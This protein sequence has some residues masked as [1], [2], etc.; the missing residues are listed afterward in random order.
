MQHSV[1]FSRSFNYLSVRRWLGALATVLAVGTLTGPA[2]GTPPPGGIAPTSF[3][4]FCRLYHDPHNAFTRVVAPHAGRSASRANA[5]NATL[6]SIQ[7]NYSNFT[8]EA[9][10]AFQAAVDIWETQLNSPV[11][12][13]VDAQFLD[14]GN[15]Q[16]LGFGAFS[17]LSFDF[18]GAPVNGVLFPDPIASRLS[19]V[20][21]NGAA[22]EIGV[23]LNT[24]PNWNYATD[25]VP[26]AGK[27]DFMSAVLH[28]LGHGFGLAGSGTVS[29]RGAL[30]FWGISGRPY[31]YDLFVAD[32]AN[33]SILDVT[34]YPNFS[35]ELGTLLRGS[36][37]SGP[38]LFWNGAQGVAANGGV[39]PRL[40]APVPF[41]PGY[42]YSHLDS[43]MFPPGDMNSLM[44]PSLASAE[45]IH[46]PGAIA[47]AMLADMGWGSQCSFGLSRRL[48]TVGAAGG[49][50]TATLSTSAGCNW[51]A[52]TTSPFATITAGGSGSASAVVAVSIAANGGGAPRLA[53]VQIADQTLTIAQAGASPCAY[54]LTPTS[55]SIGGAGGTGTLAL[56]TI[57]ACPWT[58]TANPAEALITSATSGV[59]PATVTYSIVPNPTCAARQVTL[60]IAGQPFVITQAPAP[61][62]MA[63]D[64]TSMR[65]GAVV[66]GAAFAAHTSGQIARLAQ[67]GPGA[68]TWTAVSSAPWLVVTPASGSGPAT[69][70][71]STQYVGSLAASQTGTVTLTY[72]GASNAS[73]T[74]S[75]A[76]AVVSN[77]SVAPF[78]S[79]D[80]PGD[81]ESGI[82]G[83]LPVTGWALDDVEVTRVRIL[84]DPV[85]GEP[86][87]TLVYIGDADLVNGA[88]PDLQALHPAL[89]RNSRAGW[90]YLMLTNFL[91]SLGNGVFRLTAI[92]DDAQGHSTVLGSKTITV[93][94]A[95]STAPF[96]AI[97]TPTQG[98]TVSGTLTN[99]GWVLSPAPRRA[100]P[101]AGGTVQ[102]VVDGAFVSASPGGWTS[103]PDLTALFPVAQY[104]GIATALAVAVLDTTVLSN[105]VHTIA[106][107][108]TD[109]Q[110]T[111]SGVGS[112]YFTVA[113]DV[114][115]TSG[116]CTALSV[117]GTARAAARRQVSTQ[118]AG[119]AALVWRRG[120]DRHAPY[121]T[122]Q[123]AADGRFTIESEEID[124]LE[125]QV[126][127]GA[128]GHLRVAGELA[129]LPSGS[130]LDAPTGTFT[131]QP[132]VGFVG[133]YD[134]LFGGREVR[135]VLRP[136]G[137][138]RVGPQIA[139][140]TPSAGGE[141]SGSFAVAGWAADLDATSDGGVDTVH[142]WAYPAS[143][144][145][146]IFIGAAAFG[147][148]RPDV[149]AI[150]GDRFGTSGYAI[151]VKGLA[152]GAYDLAV[153]AYST[154]S[155]G[156]APAK[157]VR[158][159]VR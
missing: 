38:G 128:T 57:P 42:S 8:A 124:R 18:A 73:S 141:A 36:G 110:G 35:I 1:A 133:S 76:L 130:R 95:T 98:G 129:P 17:S 148:S 116:T 21:R 65:F 89:P 120:Y 80:T 50:V 47:N 151:D 140:D 107:V 67:N 49:S 108:V 43:A 55:A 26:V 145:A 111:A 127:A 79:F 93:A 60:T 63:L 52:S 143:G 92:A 134:F 39:R 83:S 84:R 158:V 78:G 153:F 131:W 70:T 94:N 100:D 105:A 61:P 69:L 62:M 46:T 24:T 90:G 99:F 12:M 85:A 149:A 132:G 123:P 3:E 113:N 150:Y 101:P 102:V 135:I 64:T 136:K 16:V 7:V 51:T 155:G 157:T 13:V 137:S 74:I 88:R 114:A 59:G 5:A 41:Q 142:V 20:D 28:E 48:A 10:A 22:T 53:T 138:N 54:A 56:Q 117:V 30:G 77:P 68:V 125:L 72:T 96:G 66:S 81:G 87:G 33:V 122:A 34:K 144:E 104:P 19:G 44:T 147:G 58:A 2:G 31:V 71:I 119:S 156:F 118:S 97:D 14:L 139:I 40:F 154:V 45:V 29:S 86:A 15:P 159:T 109:N 126:G 9:Q 82:A 25:G 121:R 103:R 106:W 27:V 152:P 115:P 112:R 6:S 91:P 37:L 23:F 32:S 4:L 11:P 75:V 146:P